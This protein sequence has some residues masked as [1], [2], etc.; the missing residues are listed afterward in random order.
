MRLVPGSQTEEGPT[1][2]AS[3][4]SCSTTAA[5]GAF[6]CGNCGRALVPPC[7]RCA[8]PVALGQRFCQVCGASLGTTPP[9]RGLTDG[10]EGLTDRRL[11]TAMFCDLVGSSKL[12][13]RLD[14][15]DLAALLVAYRERCA[16]AVV[17]NGGYVSRYAGDGVLACFGYPRALDRDAQA[18][19]LSGLAIAL[20]IETLANTT[21]LRGGRDLAVRIGIETGIVL[22]GPLGPKNAIE[23]DGLVGTAPNTAARLQQ[24]APPNSVVIGEATR[25]LVAE[26]FLLEELPPLD[27]LPGKWFR[28]R[29][30]LKDRG[31]TFSRR[32]AP[33]VGRAH[34]LAMIFARW[35]DAC[36]GKGQTILLSGE[37]GIGKSRL[38]QELLD[39]A[40]QAAHNVIIL[41][42]TPPGAVSAFHPAILALR[43]RLETSVETGEADTIE[44]SLRHLLDQMGLT[45]EPTLALLL[46]TLGVGP[47]VADLAPAARRRILLQ[48][49]RT[50]LLHFPGDSPLLILVEDLHWADPSLLELLRGVTD[51]LSTRRAMLLATYRS[52]FVLPWPDRVTM[53]RLTLPPLE[54]AEAE[55]LLAALGGHHSASTRE[56]I[57]AR[58]DGVPL[59]IE[60]FT[61]AINT[62]LVP[63]T[64]QQLFTAR[65]DALGEAKRLAQCAA[66][67]A[68]YLEVDLLSELADLPDIVVE[69]RL[70]WLL[71]AEVLTR[72]RSASGSVEYTFRHALLQQ[73]ALDSLLTADRRALHAKAAERLAALRLGLV[74]QRPEIFAQHYFSGEEFTAAVPLYARAARRALAAAALD[75]A[76]AHVRRG[77]AALARLPHEAVA[78]MELDLYVLLG[79]VLI[80]KRGYANVIVQEAFE[81]ALGAAERV[82]EVARTLPALR[83]LA[84]FYQVRG[85]LSRA[86]G[87]CDK[88]VNIAESTGDLCSLVDAWRRRGWNRGCMGNPAGAEDD[89]AR[90]LQAVEPVRMEAHILTA[91]HDPQVLALANLCWLAL[92]RHGVGVATRRAEAAAAAAQGSSHSVSACYGLI[93]AALVLQQAGQVD[94]A[95][96]FAN[97]A[98]DI[99][100]EK[101]FAYWVA[102]GKVAIGYDQIVR[103]ENLQGGREAIL[104]GLASYRETQGELLR[105]FILSLVAEAEAAF[106]DIEAAQA[107][108]REA[109]DVATSLEA[110]GFL[111]EL[112]LRQARLCGHGSQVERQSFLKRAIAAAQAHGAEAIALEASRELEAQ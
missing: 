30:K 99:A 87:I 62:P 31:F 107:A 40:A 106:G 84:S 46:H 85:P 109:V 52:D 89:L 80:A 38:A 57:L 12:A 1:W 8:A 56:A 51:L 42:C 22:A 24:F 92:P 5:A 10:I 23:L 19:V 45:E 110:R 61:L 37:A 64:L 69:E 34:E 94:K 93:F 54:R 32:R 25:E 43:E 11:M 47:D 59:F 105:P 33:L 72:T 77:L 95:L 66:I 78:E 7:A 39:H 86:E 82:Q 76:E 29:G 55:Q 17:R 70:L 6:F 88:L 2:S 3:C 100:G 13:E 58:S 91:G 18:A 102:M 27:L 111:P 49:F 9:S 67:L 68:P 35:D 97:Q 75:E 63:R 41:G 36:Q 83:G 101:G 16:S 21:S 96:Q 74:E 71:D 108:L 90:A 103:R 14:P 15:E 112:I 104:K 44:Q 65:L 26:F 73:A 79:H 50:W 28:V 60:E 81:S 98:L 4:P 48:A 20:E 53:L